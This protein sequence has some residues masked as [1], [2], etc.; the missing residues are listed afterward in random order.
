MEPEFLSSSKGQPFTSGS[1]LPSLCTAPPTPRAAHLEAYPPDNAN[2]SKSSCRRTYCLW[3]KNEKPHGWRKGERHSG[4]PF[5]IPLL[6]R[7]GD[8]LCSSPSLF[9]ARRIIYER[10]GGEGAVEKGQRARQQMSRCERRRW[11]KPGMKLGAVFFRLIPGVN[12]RAAA[13]WDLAVWRRHRRGVASLTLSP[14]F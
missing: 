7:S 11:R 2:N 3:R 5:M 10:R 13:R 4:Q 1:K 12:R 14:G 9:A 6:R 8:T